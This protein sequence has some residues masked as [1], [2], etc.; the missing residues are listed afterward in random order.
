MLR[1]RVTI[2]IF[3]LGILLPISFVDAG[4]I[5]N[6][7]KYAWS[8]NSGYINFKNVIVGNSSLSGYAGRKL[9]DHRRLQLWADNDYKK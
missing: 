9:R 1:K 2:A 5:L 4:T 3:A 7:Y 6:S 8:N